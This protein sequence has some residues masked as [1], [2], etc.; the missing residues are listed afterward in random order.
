MAHAKVEPVVQ[1]SVRIP[2]SLRLR[3]KVYA[4]RS[5]I[6]VNALIA[7]GLTAL[8]DA[9]DR[10]S[11]SSALAELPPEPV[12]AMRRRFAKLVGQRRAK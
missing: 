9:E 12:D 4:A 10:A 6:P 8:L 2:A 7:E 1:L 3:M 11:R 5:G